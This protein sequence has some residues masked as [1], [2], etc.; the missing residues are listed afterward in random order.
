MSSEIPH[1]ALSEYERRDDGLWIHAGL[2]GDIAKFSDDSTGH[3]GFKTALHALHV[4]PIGTQIIRDGEARG[5]HPHAAAALV[6]EEHVIARHHFGPGLVTNVGVMALCNDGN[7]TAGFSTL[8][9]C[10]WHMS[11]TGVTAAATTDI[12]L[13]TILTPPIAV[14]GVQTL[15]SAANSQKLQTVATLTY[16]S[17]ATVTEWGLFSFATMST[18]TATITGT[19]GTSLTVTGTPYTASSASVRGQTQMIVVAGTAYGYI[20]SN[21][22]SVLTVPA[23]Y[24]VAGGTAATTPTASGTATI[25]PVMWDH[26]LFSL[27]VSNGSSAQ[28]SYLLTVASGG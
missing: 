19:T 28:F 2:V 15:V 26:K 1:G 7:N 27:P 25:Q 9:V 10:N 20:T 11:G 17:S 14:V 13:Q 6:P 5:L 16:T 24:T 22:A 12:A 3:V 8:D 18:T 21:T 23:W 4:D